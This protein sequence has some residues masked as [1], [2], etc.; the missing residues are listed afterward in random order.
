M[1]ETVVASPSPVRRETKGELKMH[2]VKAPFL[3]LSCTAV[4]YCMY[5]E[6]PMPTRGTITFTCEALGNVFLFF[7]DVLENKLSAFYT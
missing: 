3:L 1:T 5:Q 2:F 4:L 7:L 6:S